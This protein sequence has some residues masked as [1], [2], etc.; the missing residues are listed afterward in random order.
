MRIDIIRRRFPE[1]GDLSDAELIELFKSFFDEVMQDKPELRKYH[2]QVIAIGVNESLAELKS[3]IDSFSLNN[4][5]EAISGLKSSI[6]KMS[7]KIVSPPT[8]K[9]PESMAPYLA[10]LA[11]LMSKVETAVRE[12]PKAEPVSIPEPQKVKS[13]KVKRNELGY[14]SEVIPNY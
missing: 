13:L 12:I 11:R 5:Y 6:E 10:E 1:Y 2:E 3:S 14:I 4:V 8:P 7:S 9:D